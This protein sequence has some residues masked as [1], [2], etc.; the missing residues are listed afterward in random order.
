MTYMNKKYNLVEY[1]TPTADKYAEIRKAKLK[2]RNLPALQFMYHGDALQPLQCLIT[3]VPGWVHGTDYGTGEQKTRFRLDFNH[4]RQKSNDY[5]Y[6]GDSLDKSGRNPSSLFR[7]R[8]LVRY[9]E[10]TYAYGW[11]QAERELDI[12]E[13]MCIMPIS[14]EEHSFIS[15]DSAKNDITLRSFDP[16]TWGWFLKSDEN[17]EATK[18]FMGVEIYDVT[19]DFMI[20]HL[21]TIHYENI[22]QRVTENFPK[23]SKHRFIEQNT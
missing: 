18:K 5:R 16:N 10:R 11:R 8:Y 13:F 20:D 22:R 12:F 15:Q 4:I 2:N 19:R 3:G 9:T 17:F 14:G 1:F 21:S 6:A 23:L 7:D